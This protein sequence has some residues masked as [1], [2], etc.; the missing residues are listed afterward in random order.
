SRIISPQGEMLAE[1]EPH[2]PARLEATLSLETLR[3]Y[4][5]TFPAWRDADSFNW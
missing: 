1:G 4:R 2:Q 5:E 3:D